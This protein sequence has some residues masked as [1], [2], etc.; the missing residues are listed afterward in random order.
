[1]RSAS[2]STIVQ[3]CTRCGAAGTEFDLEV[4]GRLQ[5]EKPSV[6]QLMLPRSFC[7]AEVNSSSE[8]W[9]RLGVILTGFTIGPAEGI[10]KE[11]G[12][13]R[14]ASSRVRRFVSGLH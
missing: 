2:P 14:R 3:S 10:D 1:M 4:T 9:R 5:R 6:I 12:Y 8:D 7:P 13:F 11:R